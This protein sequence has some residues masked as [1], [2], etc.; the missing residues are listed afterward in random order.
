MGGVDLLMCCS[1]YPH[2]EGTMTPLLDY[3]AGGRTPQDGPDALFRDNIG[4][5]LRKN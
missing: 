4:F 5:L 1:D 3:A 2:S